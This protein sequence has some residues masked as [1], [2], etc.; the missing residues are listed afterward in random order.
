MAGTTDAELVRLTIAGSHDAYK[1]LVARYQ[2]HVYG[3]AYSLV[4]D[5]HE[6][7][8]IAQETFIRAYTNLDQLRDHGRFPAWLR[9]V[10]FSVAMNWLKT[11]R[12][13][14]FERLD[15]RV[16][17]ES[18]DVPDFQ[19]GPPEVVEK[20]DLANAV[21][22]AVASLP[23]KY[24]V[25]LSMFHLD[26][27]SYKKVAD[28]LDIPLGT[29]K[30]LIHRARAKLKAVL[31][32]YAAEEAIPMVQEV[33]NEHKLPEEFARKVLENITDLNYQE[34]GECTFSGSVAACMK[35]LN[36][37]VTYAF[38]MGVSGSAFKLLWHPSWCPSNNSLLVLGLEPIRR[39][40]R[41]LGY[42][43]Q[44]VPKRDEAECEDEFRK[45]IINSIENGCPVIAV[46]IVGPPECG[47]VAGYDRNGDVLMG[48][49][50]FDGSKDY[51]Q[52]ADW[53][54]RCY[55]LIVLG[56]KTAS[57]AKHDILLDAVQ[58]A[59]EFAQTPEKQRHDGV[60]YV[61]GL[62]AYDAWAEAL[63]RDEDFPPDD[64]EK[65]TF[66]CLVSNGVTLCGLREAR[67]TAASFLRSMA[68]IDEAARADVLAAAAAYDEELAILNEALRKVPFCESPEEKRLQMGD[69]GFRRKL[70]DI[71]LQAKGKDA[72]A[73]EHLGKALQVMRPH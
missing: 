47:I 61:S 23:P 64:L 59:V 27:L 38:V 49:S 45:R 67:M 63:G 35:F 52:E 55:S 10:G 43:Y 5:W 29:V 7:Q 69:P 58:W 28:F 32:A 54:K 22:K 18:L 31:A 51:Y 71:V 12:P 41:A 62:A 33:F 72:Q 50:Y 70:V 40:F 17:L 66:R 15:G 57:P 1:D 16:D 73:V 46:G 26:G 68:D 13:G 56:E 34:S 4:G 24:R 60:R 53:Y 44:F 3:L 9:R 11:F 42:E 25:P 19:P 21:L 36:E 30:S 14:L 8:D 2:G 6:A 37:D 20:R 65:L 39:T 48:R